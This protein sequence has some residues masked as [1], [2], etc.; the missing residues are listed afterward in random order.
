[1]ITIV[2]RRLNSS[3]CNREPSRQRITSKRAT[4]STGVHFLTYY[5]QAS[6]IYMPGYRL[7]PDETNSLTLSKCDTIHAPTGIAHNPKRFY[8]RYA[9]PSI[10]CLKRQR[11]TSKGPR[12]RSMILAS[13]PQSMS[14]IAYQKSVTSSCLV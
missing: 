7:S 1:M 13:L 12:L 11:V 10:C 14:F 5:N 2:M 9:K 8:Q 6:T 3:S 4:P